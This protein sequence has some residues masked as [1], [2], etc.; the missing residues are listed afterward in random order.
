M[1]STSASG[2]ALTDPSALAEWEDQAFWDAVAQ[3][4]LEQGA[5]SLVLDDPA[6]ASAGPDRPGPKES[7]LRVP[8]TPWQRLVHVVPWDEQLD[9]PHALADVDDRGLLARLGQAEALTTQLAAAS[10]RVLQELRARRLAR[11]A[12]AH[13]HD[14]DDCPAGA[15]CDPDGWLTAEAAVVMGL[16][17][18]QVSS[19]LTTAER[20]RRYPATAAV[21]EQGRLQVWTASV[22][23]EHLDS[24]AAYLDPVE[25]AEVESAALG[26]L[27]ARPRTVAA[28]NARMRRVLVVARAAYEAAHRGDTDSAGGAEAGPGEVVESERKVTI[29]PARAV[30]MSELVALLPEADAVAVSATLSA[31]A[32]LGAGTGDSRTTAQRRADLLVTLV[33]GLPSRAGSEADL[34][35]AVRADGSLTVH[36]DVTV[37]AAAE[38]RGVGDVPGYGP[39]P[40]PT[41]H[42]L[43]ATATSCTG[44]PLVIDTATGHL[45]GFAAR[46]VPLTWL[47]DLPP[48]RGYQHA[49]TLDAAIRLRDR[50]CRAPGCRR[51][52]A[53]C[54]CDHVVPYPSGATSLANSC[55][56][57]RRH[58]RL[59]THAPGWH[60]RVGENGDLTWT[61]PDGDT[62]TTQPHDYRPPLLQTPG[63]PPVPAEPDPP[64]F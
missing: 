52:A 24:L 36:L 27:A 20:C 39:V 49:P 14:A 22:L 19:R 50:T 51:A 37:P 56:L 8:M 21:M 11:Q 2:G 47:A 4:E 46:P 30:G 6:D 31:L 54:D 48:G 55:C 58:H 33:T 16:S 45:L 7:G 28:L 44:R 12:A 63:E 42:G 59:K 60:V 35:H 41:V 5:A 23:L 29:S 25:L 1:C 53:R 9:G 13:G 64:P 61:T 32:Q 15:C 26:W 38:E 62:T 3:S 17:E 10:G 18:R 43:A 34:D 57:C 40:A